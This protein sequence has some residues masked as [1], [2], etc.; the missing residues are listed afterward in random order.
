MRTAG[1]EVRV[2]DLCAMKWKATVDADGFPDDGGG[3]RLHVMAASERATPA[4]RPTADV[5]AEQEQ[6]RWSDA[7]ILRF[8]LW[9][10]SM[11][12]FA[13]YDANDLPEERFEAAKRAYARRLDTL[14][15][16]APV[17]YRTLTG[18]DYDMRLLPNVE[19]PGTTGLDLHVSP[20]SCQESAPA[21]HALHAPRVSPVVSAS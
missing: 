14:F 11:P 18:G 17:P 15:A 12:P 6:V 20:G 2:S 4:G 8:P 19:R 16:A 10:F 3:Q 13:I 21:P 9:W 1:H 5:A 7:V